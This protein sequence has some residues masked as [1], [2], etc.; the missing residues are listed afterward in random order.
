MKASFCFQIF[1]CKF[2]IAFKNGKKM[3]TSEA[4]RE[5]MRNK[6]KQK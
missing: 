2:I 1:T 6:N 4:I 3:N 5:F